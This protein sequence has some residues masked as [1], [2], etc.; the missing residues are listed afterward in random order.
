MTTLSLSELDAL[1][2]QQQELEKL[3]EQVEL[4]KWEREIIRARVY[5]S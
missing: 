5:V 2:S 3:K 1:N 4:L